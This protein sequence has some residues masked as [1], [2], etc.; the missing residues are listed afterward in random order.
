MGV[1][2]TMKRFRILLVFIAF[3]LTALL[4]GIDSRHHL[5]WA[6][7]PTLTPT[8][9]PITVISHPGAGDAIAGYAT[10][11]GSTLTRDCLKYSLDMSS[12][13]RENWQNLIVEYRCVANGDLYTFDTKQYKDGYYDL[14][15]RAI[16]RDGN[17]AETFLHGIEIRNSYPPTATPQ[18]DDLGSPL[19][20][21]LP[22]AFP[23]PT[24]T[25]LQPAI[26][27]RKFRGDRVSIAPK[28]AKV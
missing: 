27:H 5:L 19:P 12:A 7:L 13:G 16:R 15:L 2:N 26:R 22:T 14:R 23:L 3:A 21:P 1:C 25:T 10:I 24:I 11:K 28:S 6:Q 9:L 8:A 18:Y 20:T 17:Y 4:I